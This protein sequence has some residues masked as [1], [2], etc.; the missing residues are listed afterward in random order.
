M[1]TVRGFPVGGHTEKA[2]VKGCWIPCILFFHPFDEIPRGQFLY[3]FFKAAPMPAKA[4]ISGE[5]SVISTGMSLM[6]R[7]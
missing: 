4:G 2:M 1:R 7:M 5:G 3:L 6:R